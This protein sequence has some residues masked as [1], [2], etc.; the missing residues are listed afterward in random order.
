VFLTRQH[1]A[2]CF[3]IIA[4]G[5]AVT[6]AVPKTRHEGDASIVLDLH[7]FTHIAYVPASADLYSLRIESIKATKVATK[8]R[9]TTDQRY[10]QERSALEP[11][12]SMYCPRTS[13]ESFVRAYQVTYSFRGQP[14]ASDEYGNTNFSFSVYFRP[15]EI[16]PALRRAI[17]SG[18][19][20]GTAAAEFFRVTTSNDSLRHVVL[21]QA[22]STIC[23]GDYVDGNWTRTNPKCEDTMAYQ[24]VAR[25]SMYVTVRVNPATFPVET[26]AA[27]RSPA[28]FNHSG[29]R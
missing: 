1:I 9:V 19:I 7:P 27:G 15:D 5:S 3:A 17:S 26:A 11:G 6:A 21:D 20:K 13:D 4:W 22:N 29:D 18:K 2:T 12:G 25:P 28:P 23:E 14:I 8:V 24:S 16:G 10:C